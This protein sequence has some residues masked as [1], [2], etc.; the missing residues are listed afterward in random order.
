MV[1]RVIDHGAGVPAAV[2]EQLF[3]PFYQMDDRNPRLGTGLGLPICKGFLS[4]RTARSG[5][6]THPGGGA[7]LRF[8]LPA[9]RVGSAA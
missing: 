5:S 3:Y 8:T 7:T 1:V 4:L 6:R 9:A 2:R